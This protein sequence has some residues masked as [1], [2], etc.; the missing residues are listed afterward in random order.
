M[1]LPIPPLSLPKSSRNQRAVSGTLAVFLVILALG[2][3]LVVGI[4]LER[5]GGVG[6]VTGLNTTAPSYLSH[7]VD[8]SLFWKVWKHL[9]STY[10][11]SSVPD[12]KLFYGAIQGMVASLGDPYSVFMDPKTA[13]DFE[14]ELEGSFEGIGAEIGIRKDNLVVIAPLPGTPAE[15]AGL[16][17]GDR[18]LAIDDADTSGMAVDYAVGLIRGVKGTTVRLQIMSSSTSEPR[19]IKIVR[20]RITVQVVRGEI[21]PLPGSGS[22]AYIHI[23][24]FSSNTDEKFREVWSNLAGKGPRAIIVDLRNNPGGFLDESIDVSS[25]WLES[26]KVVVKEQFTP[27][28]MR[29]YKSTGRGELKSFPTVILVNE[30]S[31]SAAEIMAGALQDSGTATIIGQQTFGKGT[32]QDLEQFDDGSAVKLT[33]AKWF[34]PKG[35]SIDKNGITPD[36]KV[37]RTKQDYE[38]DRDP[39]L[40]RALELLGGASK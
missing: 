30:G 29:E 16:R 15:K 4:R 20:D 24:H 22:V 11:D 7:D 33:V 27:P 31:A 32:V 6:R 37:E 39:Q 14:Q 2:V 23:A 28:N 3:G 26:D 38:N 25:H 9:R 40:E 17:A 5:S 35:R 10:I 21:K 18:I 1:T 36:I 12:S 13:I 8:F 19:E 34:T